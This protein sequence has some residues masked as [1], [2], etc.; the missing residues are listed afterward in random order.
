VTYALAPYNRFLVYLAFWIGS[1]IASN[2]LARP[3]RQWVLEPFMVPGEAMSPALISGDHVYAVK[4]GPES[5]PGR[6]DVVVFRD[7][8]APENGKVAFLSRIVAAGGDLVEVRD[9]EVV[10]NGAALQQKPCAP[11]TI[12]VPTSSERPPEL[13]DCIEERSADDRPYRVIHFR[14]SGRR[15]SSSEPRRLEA[16]QLFVMGDNRDNAYDSRAW[17]PIAQRTVVG[18]AVVIWFSFSFADGLRW[19]RMGT[20][21]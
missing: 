12:T 11:P 17:G 4:V 15:I 6:G 7:P 2:V 20:R 16:D 5:R 21:P 10:V 19:G 8:E 18:R 14:G 9:G 1:T 3:L 13:V